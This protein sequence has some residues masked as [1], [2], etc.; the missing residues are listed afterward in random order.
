MHRLVVS[1]ARSVSIAAVIVS[2]SGP[3]LYALPRSKDGD[4]I[5]ARVERVL[6]RAVCVIF[7]DGI[8]DPKP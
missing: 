6:R 1:I 4:S 2:L 7:G 3:A 8:S 5:V